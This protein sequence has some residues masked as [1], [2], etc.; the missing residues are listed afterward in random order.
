VPLEKV[1]HL[2]IQIAAALDAANAQGIIHRDIKPLGFTYA[3]LTTRQP[4]IWRTTL[5]PHCFV[6]LG[7]LPL[8]AAAQAIGCKAIRYC[9]VNI[10]VVAELLTE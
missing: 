6:L 9:T 4:A 10:T 2:G 5:L 8:H 7:F 1:L 3:L